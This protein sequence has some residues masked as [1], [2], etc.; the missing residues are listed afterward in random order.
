MVAKKISCD[1]CGKEIPDGIP[2][3]HFLGFYIKYIKES[4][5][6]RGNLGKINSI[7]FCNYDC[8]KEYIQ[9]L[10]EE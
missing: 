2:R 1:N 5:N 3:V 7:D 4:I 9:N 8:T 10:K 6:S